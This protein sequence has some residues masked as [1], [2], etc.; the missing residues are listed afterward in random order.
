MIELRDYQVGALSAVREAW[1]EHP[2]LVLTSP[3]GGGKTLMAHELMREEVARGGRAWFCAALVTLVQQ[4]ALRFHEYGSAAG[5]VQA[6]N[7]HRA[8]LPMLVCSG[9]TLLHRDFARIGKRLEC[10]DEL[11][12]SCDGKLCETLYAESFDLRSANLP[13]LLIIDECHEAHRYTR[14]VARAVTASGGRVVGLTATP[15]AKWMNR[16]YG[17]LIPT[18]STE[19]LALRG[20]LVPPVYKAAELLFD[21]TNANG[22]A[23][24]PQGSDEHAEY[25]K[26]QLERGLSHTTLGELPEIWLR[27]TKARYGGPVPTLVSV[28]LI[29][30]GRTVAKEFTER[31]GLRFE[32]CSA[33]DGKDGLP[34]TEEVLSRFDAGIT[35]GLVS[36]QKL[37]I[38]FDRPNVQC[39]VLARPYASLT[40]MAQMIG[41]GL[42]TNGA[43][44]DCLVL[45]HGG[46]WDRLGYKFQAHYNHGPQGFE[47][48]REKGD[49]DEVI[50][51]D[52]PDCGH[53][54]VRGRKRCE[55]CGCNLVTEKPA[56]EI[57]ADEV[58]MRE[59]DLSSDL[60]RRLLDPESDEWLHYQISCMAQGQGEKQ[61][62][63]AWKPDV[64]LAQDIYHAIRTPADHFACGWS[65]SL[66]WA[67]ESCTSRPPWGHL[68]AWANPVAIHPEFK[69]I[70]DERFA[71]LRAVRVLTPRQ[72]GALPKPQS[73]R[74]KRCRQFA[75]VSEM[76]NPKNKCGFYTV[77]PACRGSQTR[78]CDACGTQTRHTYANRGPFKRRWWCDACAK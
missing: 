48:P 30:V 72:R 67:L 2:A 76:A 6:D 26:S 49:P 24:S 73:V 27:E 33:R 13:S 68:H 65:C 61:G 55:F 60:Y 3:T 78:R 44:A 77:C 37:A 56:A 69:P 10:D 41:R 28:P 43:K 1:S 53:A 39:I 36:V 51:L 29:E 75:P 7:T 11:C 14:R 70:A 46:N 38:G 47:L 50:L 54:N 20:A 40:P 32:L 64:S 21:M 71:R 19:A 35:V 31:T 34:T 4:T 9:Q 66:S 62:Y 5:M 45:D 23:M 25:S 59:I 16:S 57:S 74:C 42:R 18:A 17:D 22:S 12:D 52:C 15:Y 58:I 8:H 63:H